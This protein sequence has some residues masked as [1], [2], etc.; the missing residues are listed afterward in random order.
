MFKSTLRN[1][2]QWTKRN[3]GILSG[4]KKPSPKFLHLGNCLGSQFSCFM[5][6]GSTRCI[7]SSPCLTP[8]TP[9]SWNQSE[10]M[11]LGDSKFFC[12]Y[13]ISLYACLQKGSDLI[14]QM[15]TQPYIQSPTVY[16]MFVSRSQWGS[17]NYKNCCSSLCLFMS[18][19]KQK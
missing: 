19:L 15:W 16:G 8:V 2:C 4:Q 5:W 13:L 7:T 18:N 3:R 14:R 1:T 17:R 10:E 11:K 6:G 9:S 12:Y